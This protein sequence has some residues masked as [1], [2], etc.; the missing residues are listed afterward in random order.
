[1]INVQLSKG[2]E[3]DETKLTVIKI[4]LAALRFTR[5]ARI[6][7]NITARY[8]TYEKNLHSNPDFKYWLGFVFHI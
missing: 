5:F 7:V 6:F 2:S 8:C 4:A 3:R 1:M